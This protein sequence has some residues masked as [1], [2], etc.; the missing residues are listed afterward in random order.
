[1][2]ISRYASI[3]VFSLSIVITTS[4]ASGPAPFPRPTGA[5]REDQAATWVFFVDKGSVRLPRALAELERNYSPRAIE[6]RRLRRSV[7]GLFDERDVPVCDD[8]VDA[9]RSTGARVRTVSCWLNAV[10]V[11]ACAEQL[12]AVARLPFVDRIQPV[13]GYRARGAILDS[14]GGAGVSGSRAFYGV[15]EAQLDQIGLIDLHTR[16]FTAD[17]V[18]I[19]VLDTGF[20]CTHD[21]FQLP[22]HPLQVVAEWDFVNNDPN[23]GPEAGDLPNQHE[24]GTLILGTMGAYQPNTI[25]GGAYDAAFVLAKVEDVS[26]EYSLEEDFFVAGLQFIEANGGDVA[27]SSLIIRDVYGADDLDGM[28]SVMTV[29]FNTA[30]ENGVHCFQGAGNE[31]NDSDPATNHLMFPADAIQTITVGAIDSAGQT[32]WFSSDGPTVDGR[33]K[34]EVLARGVNTHTVSHDSDTT[35]RTASGTSL[36]TPLAAAVAACLVSAHPDWTVDQMRAA[37]M[38]TADGYLADGTHDPLFVRGYGIL[39]A[40]AAEGEMDPEIYCDAKHS[41]ADCLPMVFFTGLPSASS[42]GP[43]EVRASMIPYNQFGLFFYGTSGSNDLPFKGGTLCVRGPFRRTP[44]Q[45]S[46]GTSSPHQCTGHFTIDFNARI[47]SGID[48]TLQAGVEVYGQYWFRDPPDTFGVGLS[49][50]IHFTIAP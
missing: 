45:T 11:E 36:A 10:S 12:A 32:A 2:N 49:D 14:P 31:G 50:A 46:G 18:I 42:P 37:L 29:G 20:R 13:R 7:P 40:D 27:T 22:A 6:R 21:A 23:T 15:S 24:H 30:T 5:E 16:G 48:P 47:Q 1:M 35:T 26:S 44:V 25:V 9:L 33:V 38:H 39:D 19:G 43:F 8:Y 4:S 17:G 3:A 34:P 28:T 41:S